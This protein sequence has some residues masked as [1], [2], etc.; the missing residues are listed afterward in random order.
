MTTNVRATLHDDGDGNN[1]RISILRTFELQDMEDA[2]ERVV[3]APNNDPAWL[4]QPPS[5]DVRSEAEFVEVVAKNDKLVFRP[6]KGVTMSRLSLTRVFMA[7]GR[8]LGWR[9]KIDDF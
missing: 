8:L 6:V 3:T 9:L 1:P 2:L 4:Q 7:M 5:D